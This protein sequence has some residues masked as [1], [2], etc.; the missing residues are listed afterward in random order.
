MPFF[1]KKPVEVEAMQFTG[2]NYEEVISWADSDDVYRRT[3]ESDR[4]E[5]VTH[6]G[7][8]QA[9]KGDW[10]VKGVDGEFYPCRPDV[11]EKTYHRI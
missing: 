11:F 10:V 9:E 1:R 5:V 8:A 6:H 7:L 3:F 2:D 4:I